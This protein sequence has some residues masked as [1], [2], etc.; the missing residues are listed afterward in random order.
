[1]T[2]RPPTPFPP[3]QSSEDDVGFDLDAPD[4]E[5]ESTGMVATPARAFSG[6]SEPS[7]S[8]P[9]GGLSWR[10]R[11]TLSAFAL[12]TLP[13]LAIGASLYGMGRSILPQWLNGADREAPATQAALVRTLAQQRRWLE[14]LSLGTGAM[15]IAAGSTAAALTWRHLATVATVAAT[16]RGTAKRLQLESMSSTSD[17]MLQ[18]Q[19]DASYIATQL[20]ELVWQR[21]V[22]AEQVAAISALEA[23]LRQANAVDEI[24]DATVGIV[25]KLLEADR[26]AVFRF[27]ASG[28]GTFVA[29]SVASIYPKTL[30]ATIHDPCFSQS[31]AERYEQGRILA[32]HDIHNAGL[33]DCHI[34]LLERFAVKANLIGPL[35]QGDRLFGLL[36]AH[37]CDAPRQWL[38]SEIELMAQITARVGLALSFAERLQTVECSSSRFLT[39][40]QL[41]E[42]LSGLR[43]E[44]EVFQR[45]AAILRQAL[46]VDDVTA[47]A[48]DEAGTGC[49]VGRAGDIDLDAATLTEQQFAAA[50]LDAWRSGNVDTEAGEL[51]ESLSARA[52]AYLT[53]PILQQGKLLGVFFSRQHSVDRVWSSTDLDV[54]RLLAART[55]NALDTARCFQTNERDRLAALE[56]ADR[57]SERAET[58]QQQC[59]I[60]FGASN[61]PSYAQLQERSQ[62]IEELQRQVLELVRASREVIASERQVAP[63]LDQ[64]VSMASEQLQ[65]LVTSTQTIAT[66][67][68][69]AERQRYRVNQALDTSRDAIELVSATFDMA[70]DM[71]AASSQQIDVLDGY[72]TTI[73]TAIQQ[74]L[75]FVEQMELYA[76][77][78]QAQTLP[79]GDLQ[80]ERLTLAQ[81]VSSTTRRL[82]SSAAELETLLANLQAEARKASTVVA[83]STQQLASGTNLMTELRQDFERVSD[84]NQRLQTLMADA[85]AVALSQ[86]QAANVASQTVMTLATSTDLD[87][88]EPVLD[89]TDKLTKLTTLSR[90]LQVGLEELKI[91]PLGDAGMLSSNDS[92]EFN[93]E[94]PTR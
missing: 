42:P 14:G 1:M 90:E 23:S 16:T 6:V 53:V 35:M 84:A 94:T 32:I 67:M 82:V 52:S 68:Q 19:A 75:H 69:S 8:Y 81:Q 46:D 54:A 89:V 3:G 2:Q 56:R 7:S 83:N 27:D 17:D 45:A 59:S 11:S 70:G 40:D 51:L 25:R 73:A 85:I 13:V 47:I 63:A 20:P 79:E 60:V 91:R 44:L 49:V 18:F 50:T 74:M 92:D 39:L 80:T 5:T 24:F 48:I 9:A 93:S 57:A 28:E 37:Q 66:T 76:L 86:V 71:S 15:A 34:G 78:A 10:W 55:G 58:L 87:R 72:A 38:S 30:Q 43:D 88:A 31:F 77:E 65:T 36:I 41:T 4:R 62:H 22:R 61:M 29:E 12:G 33:T 64:T 21:E 26:V